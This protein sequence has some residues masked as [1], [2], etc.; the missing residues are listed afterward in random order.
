MKDFIPFPYCYAHNLHYHMC[1][2]F[3]LVTHVILVVMVL[4][5]KLESTVVFDSFLEG[6]SSIGSRMLCIFGCSSYRD[7]VSF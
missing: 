3:T 6:H 2:S 7:I 1:I 4:S 5:K